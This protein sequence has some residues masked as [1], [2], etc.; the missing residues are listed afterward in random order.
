M[1]NDVAFSDAFLIGGFEGYQL[2]FERGGAPWLE[3]Y[4]DARP[5]SGGAAN[6][7]ALIGIVV[8]PAPCGESRADGL[9]L[10][11]ARA[12]ATGTGVPVWSR[13]RNGAGEWMMD[14]DSS[15]GGVFAFVLTNG[16][17]IYPGGDLIFAGGVIGF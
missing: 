13:L 10:Y 17:T 9:H 11:P 16:Q 14:G 15:V 4:G 8:L 1:S 2:T 6:A 3:V 7:A 12:Q 5:D